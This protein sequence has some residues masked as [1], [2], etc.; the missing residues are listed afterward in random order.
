[1]WSLVVIN[2]GSSWV[3]PF[4]YNIYVTFL[5]KKSFQRA[6]EDAE[7]RTSKLKEEFH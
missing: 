6:A 1:M 2:I 7:I 4:V 5:K 3:Y